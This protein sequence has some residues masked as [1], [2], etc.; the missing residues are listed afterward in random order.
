MRK[1]KIIILLLL[2]STVGYSQTD[3]NYEYTKE[4]TWGINKNTNGGLIGGVVM[5]FSR[6]LT[7]TQFR[8]I[9]FEAINVKHQKEYKISSIDGGQY[10]P[11][12]SHHLFA[13]RGQYGR[14]FI[15]FKKAPQNGVQ[16]N[17]SVAAGPSFGIIAPYFVVLNSTGE[18][19]PYT[20]SSQFNDVQG[21]GSVMEGLSKASI[22]PGLNAKASITFEMGAFKSNVTG[23]ELGMLLEAYPKKV[24]LMLNEEN[25]AVYFSGFITIFYG[26]RR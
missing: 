12:K 11:G 25:K 1:Q 9:G 20:D 13:I 6:A 5:K 17:A 10:Q 23:F 14:D 4:F 8:T 15:L 19:V 18:S 21:S 24:E 16:I 2:L 3:G 7:D 26:N 22:R